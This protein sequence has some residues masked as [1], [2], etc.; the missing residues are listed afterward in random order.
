MEKALSESE[1]YLWDFIDKHLIDIPN[2]S[3]VKLSEKANVST[4]TIVRAMKKKGYEGFTSF[5]HHLKDQSNTTINFSGVEKID[6]EIKRAILKNEQE[7]IRTINMLDSGSI[8]DAIQKI[9]AAQKIVI[10]ARGFSELIA[11]E[12]MVKFQLSG[13]YCEMHADPNIITS[14]SKKITKNDIV[15]LISLNGETSELVT[16]VKNC[17]K[18]DVS[19]ITLTANSS[20]SLAQLSEI[21]FTGFKSEGS[22]FPE[23]EVRSRLPLSIMAR[24]LL[25]SYA[26]RTT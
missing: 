23:Y 19:T 9:K 13:K 6:A 12:M 24:I 3:I 7:M 26:I 1:K 20:S 22:Y 25:D 8:E 17:L 4:A 16:A 18:N 11:Q 5:K 15:L 10:F 2:Y 14:M 21:V